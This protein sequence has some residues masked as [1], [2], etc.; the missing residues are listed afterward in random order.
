M[1]DRESLCH[2]ENVGLIFSDEAILKEDFSRR[3]V[4][5]S[6]LFPLSHSLIVVD[7]DIGLIHHCL[8]ARPSHLLNKAVDILLELKII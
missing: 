7:K 3:E 6:N 2:L 5:T 4:G 1:T 8:M